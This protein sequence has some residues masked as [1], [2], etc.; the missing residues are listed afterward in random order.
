MPRLNAH[1]EPDQM[2]CNTMI[3]SIAR[4]FGLTAEISTEYTRDRVWAFVRCKQ[5]SADRTGAVIVQAVVSAPLRTAK[6]LYIYHYAALLDCWHQMDRGVLA[7]ATT[8]IVRGW[9]G[10]PKAPARRK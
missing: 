9:D 2:D 7:A 4:D 5:P 10:R 3:T 1:Y 6:S 8:P